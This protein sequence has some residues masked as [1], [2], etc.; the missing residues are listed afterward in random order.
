MK[1][2]GCAGRFVPDTEAHLAARRRELH[3][4]SGTKRSVS[5]QLELEEE[6]KELTY[7]EW[8]RK[9]TTLSVDLEI[10]IQLGEMTVKKHALE[11][12]DPAYLELPDFRAVIG[13][14]WITDKNRSLQ[15]QPAGKCI[16][17]Y[18]RLANASGGK[19][20]RRI[21]YS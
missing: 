3:A 13:R 2:P 18:P 12:L 9:K 7:E 4:Y 5:E 8:L 14:R 11:P 15:V 21:K 1:E 16:Q 17:N 19:T 10:N 6:E 20:N